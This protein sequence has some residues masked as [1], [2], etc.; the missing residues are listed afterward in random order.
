MDSR[1]FAKSP[2][3][4][5][6]DLSENWEVVRFAPMMDALFLLLLVLAEV[7]RITCPAYSLV[8]ASAWSTLLVAVEISRFQG[9]LITPLIGIYSVFSDTHY[10]SDLDMKH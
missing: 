10:R 8:S 9:T 6:V 3:A 7:C 2:R 5:N 1:N 4:E